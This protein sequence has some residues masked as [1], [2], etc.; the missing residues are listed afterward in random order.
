MAK[1]LKLETGYDDEVSI[2][3]ISCHKPDYWIALKINKT[4]HLNLVHLPS[5]IM[6]SAIEGAN[7]RYYPV[8]FYASDDA[9][10]SYYLIPN[11]SQEGKLF[12]DQKIFDYFMPVKG[13]IRQNDLTGMISLM[14]K[15][16]N[17]LTAQ[18]L[19]RKNIK[20]LD[21]FLGEL[22]VFMLEFSTKRK[23]PE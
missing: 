7:P 10:L 22:E 13:R 3:G 17:V 2:I 9:L 12:P 14:K 5:D 19:N 21:E 6:F 11:H 4:L 18:N 15:I 16:P 20:N 1:K 23:K 8:F